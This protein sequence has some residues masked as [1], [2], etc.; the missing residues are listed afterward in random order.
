VYPNAA[1]T[2]YHIG[3]LHSPAAECGHSLLV[4][5]PVACCQHN[6]GRCSTMLGPRHQAAAGSVTC[7]QLLPPSTA[8]AAVTGLWTAGIGIRITRVLTPVVVAASSLVGRVS[9]WGCCC[10]PDMSDAHGV[11]VAVV[12]GLTAV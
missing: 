11:T 2:C 6:P 9:K 5:Q 12:V 3:Q 4:S 10:P 7:V 8:A 1:T